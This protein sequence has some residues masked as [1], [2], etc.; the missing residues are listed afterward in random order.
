VVQDVALNYF[1]STM[2]AMPAAMFLTMMTVDSDPGAVSKHQLNTFSLSF[3]LIFFLS[4]SL[5]LS[6]FLSF[7]FFDSFLN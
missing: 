3:F 1:S 5:S 2:P 4:L 6:L 7:F